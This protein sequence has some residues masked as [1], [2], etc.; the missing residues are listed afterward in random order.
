MQTGLI[1]IYCGDGKG[2]TTAAMGLALRCSGGGGKVLIFQFLKPGNSGELKSLALLPQVTLLEG[3]KK[4][5]F[6][7]YMNEEEKVE[8]TTFYTN[9][10]EEIINKVQEE[11]YQLLILDEAIG[12]MNLGYIK[13]ERILEFLKNKPND[14]EVV[15]TG[16]NPSD[17][18]IEIANYVSEIKKVKHPFEQGIQARKL[19]EW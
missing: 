9:R 8:A 4:I 15:L 17:K 2:K 7:K 19:I 6:S 11:H 10:L 3:Y 13:E 5:K 18:M 1:H 16:R 14:L 12:A